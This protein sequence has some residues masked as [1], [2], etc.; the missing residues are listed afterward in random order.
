M[1]RRSLLTL[2]FKPRLLSLHSYAV[3]HAILNPEGHFQNTETCRAYT[4]D[5]N[6]LQAIQNVLA[7]AVSKVLPKVIK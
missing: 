3:A 6:R 5:T 7:R 4:T 1:R 2:D